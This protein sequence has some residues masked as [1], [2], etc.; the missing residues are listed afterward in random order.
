[1]TYSALGV[2]ISCKRLN[3]FQRLEFINYLSLSMSEKIIEIK[4]IAKKFGLFEAVK[5][6]SFHVNQ[7]DV[8]GFLGPNGA[9]KSTTIRCM[10]SLIK[11]DSG[12]IKIFGK[13]IF[14]DRNEILSRTGSI[15]EKPDFYKYLSAYKNLEIFSRLS[16]VSVGKKEIYKMQL[17]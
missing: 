9:G 16:R 15:I 1:L 17:I 3:F 7:G 11:P 14:T 4:S 8:Y 10:L 13:S 2:T 5:D 12:T 6:V